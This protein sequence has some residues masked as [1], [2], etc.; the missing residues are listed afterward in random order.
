MWKLLLFYHHYCIYFQFNPLIVCYPIFMFHKW[1]SSVILYVCHDV[2]RSL[3]PGH[4]WWSP[5][6][7]GLLLNI[8]LILTV[9]GSYVHLSS[10]GSSAHS[11]CS[12]CSEDS[13]SLT[14]SSKDG[15]IKLH[16]STHTN[17][18]LLWIPSVCVCDSGANWAL[19]I[20]HTGNPQ[21]GARTTV[22]GACLGK[23]IHW[24]WSNQIIFL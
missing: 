13:P 5:A 15:Q 10:T 12:H 2:P 17:M 14:F 23:L 11:A 21:R 16:S 19:S 22:W 18:T 8:S 6:A 20:C 24:K 3:S 4:T 9:C 7:D 1:C